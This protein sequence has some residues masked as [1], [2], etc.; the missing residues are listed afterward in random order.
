LAAAILFLAWLGCAGTARAIAYTYDPRADPPHNDLQALCDLCSDDESPCTGIELL[1]D[2]NGDLTIT[3]RRNTDWT[4]E[5]D[6]FRVARYLNILDSAVPAGSEGKLNIHGGWIGPDPA[7]GEVQAGASATVGAANVEFDGVRFRGQDVLIPDGPNCQRT[8]FGG[9]VQLQGHATSSTGDAR[10]ALFAGIVHGSADFIDCTFDFRF[11]ATGP[12][13]IGE[14]F[15]PHAIQATNAKVRIHNP[16]LPEGSTKNFQ[17]GFIEAESSLVHLA[18]ASLADLRIVPGGTVPHP[19]PV[20]VSSGAL[21]N[22]GNDPPGTPQIVISASHFTGCSGGH[23]GAVSIAGASAGDE[24]AGVLVKGPGSFSECRGS[25]S[26]ALAVYDSPLHLLDCEF[27]GNSDRPLRITNPNSHPLSLENLVFDGTGAA[28][29]HVGPSVSTPGNATC[30]VR[31][32]LSRGYRRGMELELAAGGSGPGLLLDGLTLMD[33]DTALAVDSCAAPLFLFN[34]NLVAPMGITIPEGQGRH[35]TLGHVNADGCSTVVSGSNPGAKMDRLTRHASSFVGSGNAAAASQLRWDS[36]L[37]D[38]GTGTGGGNEVLLD[39]DF[40]YTRRDIGYKRRFPVTP[41]YGSTRIGETGWY[42]VA[43]KCR[44]EVTWFGALPHGSVFRVDQGAELRLTGSAAGEC[45]FGDA[46]GERTMIVPR[47]FD[48]S[49]SADAVVFHN[50]EGGVLAFHGTMFNGLPGILEFDDCTVA[51]DNN[52]GV[53][54]LKLDPG[55]G[56]QLHNTEIMFTDCA[57]SVS[58]YDFRRQAMSDLQLGQL[59]TVRSSV[60]VHNCKFSKVGI[61]QDFAL[62]ME[63]MLAG[64]ATTIRDCVFDGSSTDKVPLRLIDTQPDLRGNRFYKV[65]AMAL[66]ASLSPFSMD[67]NAGNRFLSENVTNPPFLDRLILL[68][69]SPAYL[70]CGGN[71]FVYNQMLTHPDFDFI[72]YMGRRPLPRQG[73]TD[74]TNYDRNFWGEDCGFRISTKGRIPEWADPGT[75]LDSCDTEVSGCPDPDPARLLFAGEAQEMR[76][77]PAAA[78]DIYRNLI[79]ETPDSRDAFVAAQRLK[80]IAFDGDAQIGPVYLQALADAVSHSA[81]I[82]PAYLAGATECLRAWQGDPQT[83]ESN[84]RA[85][86]AAAADESESAVFAKNLLELGT[87]HLSNGRIGDTDALPSRARRQARKALLTFDPDRH[88]ESPGN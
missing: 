29:H 26:G 48:N 18:S 11:T 82:L 60:S 23:A 45:H 12:C 47:N 73:Q 54:T 24:V 7:S 83:A 14:G 31:N 69:D 36:P 43:D 71:R 28:S 75:E 81:S 58:N 51:L 37:L 65:G 2:W 15:L 57:G 77:N 30:Q 17:N 50:E 55:P 63:G 61:N 78:A 25:D 53:Q 27:L 59:S 66:S 44:A 38:I 72:Q 74:V 35:L 84:L 64:F 87:Y 49:L 39:Y 52:S 80:A 6:G 9:L 42:T 79:R 40:D 34:S 70:E 76:C 16:S 10:H 20:L 88:E 67:H 41:L 32:L 46:N 5:A 62:V 1:G 19:A 21:K 33:C 3:N 85:R 4:L 22:G 8:G 56:P 86:L 13:Q 68:H